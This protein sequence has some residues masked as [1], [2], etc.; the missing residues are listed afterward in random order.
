MNT[1]QPEKAISQPRPP[2]KTQ[3]KI[4]DA[5]NA[6][7]FQPQPDNDE[8]AFASRQLVQATLP[9]SNPQGNPPVWSRTNGNYTLLIKPGYGHNAKTGKVVCL[10]YPYGTLPRLILFWITKEALR[11]GNRHLELGSTLSSFL[12]EIGL[13][14]STGRGKRGDAKRLREQMERLFS[15]TISFEYTTEQV[16]RWLNMNVTSN[17]E[18]WWDPRQPDQCDLWGSWIDLGAEFFE[19]ITKYPV[20][21]DMRTIRALKKSPMALDLY[22]WLAYRTFTLKGK[23]ATI[24]WAQINLQL[25]SHYSGLNDFVKY[26]KYALRK[27]LAIYPRLRVEVVYGGLRLSPST[28]LIAPRTVT[29][30][31]NLSSKNTSKRVA[32]KT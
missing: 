20:P 29:P 16:K 15:A 25:G 21:L 10:G 17:G 3:R 12:R 5:V 19:A 8:L 14:P 31:I 1:T 6:V 30:G 13:D 7:Y 4:L 26:A 27:V 23:P 28:S 2:T 11:T 32:Q 9:H 18:L 22:A 24:S